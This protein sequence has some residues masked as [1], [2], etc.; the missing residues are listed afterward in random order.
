MGGLT[1]HA[2]TIFFDGLL[3]D[4]DI[5]WPEEIDHLGHTAQWRKGRKMIRI[6]VARPLDAGQDSIVQ[7]V[8]CTMLHEMAHAVFE[9]LVCPG[10]S[11][12]DRAQ[13]K[14]CQ[15]VREAQLGKMGHGEAWMKLATVLAPF[16]S[17]ELDWIVKP[18][19]VRARR[20]DENSLRPKRIQILRCCSFAFRASEVKCERR[21]RTSR[22]HGGTL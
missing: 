22:R 3:S 6:R 20:G 5:E 9:L 2:S 10:S 18:G 16:V 1:K 14:A 11:P 4:R 19:S 17:S 13:R 15:P 12:S 7:S 21:S 8:V